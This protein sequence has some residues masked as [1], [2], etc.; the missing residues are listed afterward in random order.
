MNMSQEFINSVDEYALPDAP[1]KPVNRNN[2]LKNSAIN[3]KASKSYKPISFLNQN[4]KASEF[5]KPM[6]ITSV[7]SVESLNNEDNKKDGV[8][9]IPKNMFQPSPQ[10]QTN[11]I[12]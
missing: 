7:D 8:L 12:Q 4:E 1:R 2:T 5:Q 3:K 6:Q 11:K 10:S 9:F